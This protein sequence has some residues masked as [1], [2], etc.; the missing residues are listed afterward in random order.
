MKE[1]YKSKQSQ[2]IFMELYDRQLNSLNIEH[3][4]LYIDTSFG[5]THV[6]KLGNQ[7]GKPL[8]I[9]HGGNTTAPYSLKYL[10]ALPNHF[11][12]YAVDTIGHPGKSSQNVVS[13]KSMEYG[14]WASDVISGLGFGKM[15]CLGGSFGGG[16]L[17]KLMCVAPEKIEKAVLIVPA[18]I[19]NVSTLN[20]IATMGIPMI[21]YIITKKDKWLKKAILPM[22]IDEKNIDEAAYEMAKTSFEH[23]A[24][25]ADMPSNIKAEFLRNFTAPTFVIVA[26]NDNMFPCKKVIARAEKIIPNLKTHVL[27]GSGHMFV[28][29]G[30]D[31][32][33]IINFIK[34]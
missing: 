4:D 25:K 27:K 24:V 26:E 31:I 22:A 15:N 34:N 2:S 19:A 14:E 6:I 11:C 8:L 12:V 33:M 10:P 16:I 23:V 28:L 7:N 5:K 30:E 9:F 1:I 20:L 21:F 17:A 3:E 18:G 32:D 13:H 29:S